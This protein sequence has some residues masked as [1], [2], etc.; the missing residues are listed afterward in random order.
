[1]KKNKIVNQ[2]SA[3]K[4]KKKRGYFSLFALLFS[5]TVSAQ[6][7][8][9]TAE[10]YVYTK[11]CLDADCVKKAETVQYFDGLGRPL[12]T[13][14]INATPQGKDMVSPIEYNPH[15]KQ[16]KSYLPIPQ[17][18]AGGAFY[19]TPFANV[20]N[21]Y[22]NEKIY[23]EKVY[24]NIY[25]DRIKKV[26]PVGEAWAQKSVEMG[27][28][29]NANG[30][31]RKY[32]VTTENWIEG[33]T[34][35]KITLSGT[36]AA[37]QLMKTSITDEDG[38]ITTEFQNGEGQTVLVRKNDGEHDVDTY[39]LYNEFG[40]LAYVIPPLAVA[41]TA[42]DLTVLSNLCYQYRYDGMGRTVEKKLP[43][44]GWE[45]IV[46]D[47]Q[48][49]VVAVQ[50]AVMRNKG[51]WLYTKYDRFG[52]V[53]FTGI[54]T[55]GERSTEQGIAEAYGNNNATRTSGVFF[56]REGMDVYYDPNGTYPGVGWVK[57]LSVNYYDTYPS[58]SFNPAF[59]GTILGE[60]I[61]TDAQNASVNTLAM[62]TLSLVKNIEDDN[63]TKSYLY[64]DGKGRIVGT[65][66]I[67]HLGGYTKTESQLDFAGVTKQTKVYHKRQNIDTERVISQTFEYDS[68]NRLKKQWHQ[69]DGRASELMA[70]NTYNELSQLSNKKVGNNL[71]SI[72]Y[73]YN[74]RGSLIKVND[75]ANLGTQLFGYEV[76][77]QNPQNTSVS[78]GKYN[79]NISEVIWKTASDHIVRQYNYQYDALNRLKKGTYSEPG[80]SVPQNGMFNETVVYDVNSN[81]TSLQRNGKSVS[82]S[83]QL[84]DNLTYNYSGNKLNSITD[85][86]GN[87]NGY[88]DTSGNTISY[89]DNG[90]MKDHIDKGVLK[91]DY[92]IL[93]LP[94]YIEF[95]KLYVS[96]E[97]PDLF[98]NVNTKHLYRADGT[99]LQKTY[100]SGSGKT[101][102]ETV[103]ITDYLDGF[104]YE[105]RYTGTR[106]APV[107][108]FVPTA[109][110][111][112]NFENNKY[113]YSYTDHLGNVRL[114]YS[115]NTSGSAEVLE[116]N[117]FYPFGLKHEGYN[118]LTGNPAYN[119]EYNGKELQK[120]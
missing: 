1:M 96:R 11:N 16:V 18:T 111:Y 62:P 3:L 20:S 97:Y 69:V 63:W 52:R 12:Q 8:L 90:N 89:D 116:E 7:T 54:S 30:E 24:D 31:V 21:T 66:S 47:K 19:Q 59:P 28:D 93:N 98:F 44:K 118:A 114:S 85:A 70:E 99:K 15:G 77:Y 40:Q 42:P 92:N 35:S 106:T 115:K 51:Q 81:I 110:G 88:P 27:Y 109:E 38:N 48:D 5:L 112:Y 34:D 103:T 43:G 46:Y 58:Y 41:N 107:L 17:Q 75:P 95:D 100:T 73:T 13:I 26:I 80:A 4:K 56:N 60:P 10:N 117:N 68:Q 78:V 67:N 76:K 49:R 101:N 50:D 25:T 61:I 14:A 65:Y 119:Y 72:N 83:A 45:F 6:T 108:K 64:Y 9:S 22:G 2:F 23:S 74:V 39:Y 113:I 32:M 84:I 102:T 94:D 105:S 91:I 86:S 82:S 120:E 104:Q 79:G 57:L 55:G 87:Y 53:A 36:Y 33:R 37:N 71:Q 29:T